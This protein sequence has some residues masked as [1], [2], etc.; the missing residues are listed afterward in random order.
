[1]R[2][3]EMSAQFYQGVIIG[4]LLIS[5]FAMLW[6]RLENYSR[7]RRGHRGFLLFAIMEDIEP[8]DDYYGQQGSIRLYSIIVF[9]IT[10]WATSKIIKMPEVTPAP[11]PDI[12][13]SGSQA[14]NK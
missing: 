12:I 8:I 9:N 4:F 1:M 10:I 5:L 13:L 2:I 3:L 6:R 11:M 7:R 14:V